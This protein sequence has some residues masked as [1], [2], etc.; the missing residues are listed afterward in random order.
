MFFFNVHGNELL[1][2]YTL[3]FKAAQMGYVSSELHKLLLLTAKEIHVLDLTCFTLNIIKTVPY[4][5]TTYPVK[6]VSARVGTKS[7]WIHLL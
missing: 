2:C 3:G 6:K 4:V 7:G 1:H 5:T